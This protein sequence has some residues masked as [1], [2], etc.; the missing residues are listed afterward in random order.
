MHWLTAKWN[1]SLRVMRGNAVWP[2]VERL[3]DLAVAIVKYVRKVGICTLTASR[4][5][6]R[7]KTFR[8]CCEVLRKCYSHYQTKD[9]KEQPLTP[10]SH[11]NR[12][13]MLKDATGQVVSKT[14]KNGG[15]GG[16]RFFSEIL[17]AA[18]GKDELVVTCCSAMRIL[19]DHE[20]R[21][22]RTVRL[23]RTM[24]RLLQLASHS[25]ATSLAGKKLGTKKAVLDLMYEYCRRS[26]SNRNTCTKS[27]SIMQILLNHGNSGSASLN[28]P[29]EL[30]ALALLQLL[31]KKNVKF[32]V[33]V[34]KNGE[35]PAINLIS[36]LLKLIKAHRSEPNYIAAVL[37]CL[38]ACVTPAANA[39]FC[40]ADSGGATS[41]LPCSAPGNPI[42]SSVIAVLQTNKIHAHL[43]CLSRGLEV[44][45]CILHRRKRNARALISGDAT[46]DVSTLLGGLVNQDKLGAMPFVVQNNLWQVPVQTNPLHVKNSTGSDGPG[47]SSTKRVFENL[48]PESFCDDLTLQSLGLERISG[49][50]SDVADRPQTEQGA[51]H[52]ADGAPRSGVDSETEKP[53]Q[54]GDV[55]AN[56][57]CRGR[58]ETSPERCTGSGVAVVPT[59]DG[60]CI[61]TIDRNVCTVP[62]DFGP[63]TVAAE[64][65]PL[66]YPPCWVEQYGGGTNTGPDEATIAVVAG[67]SSNA[68]D[69]VETDTPVS[70]LSA[71]AAEYGIS[72]NG[73]VNVSGHREA[74]ASTG[75]SPEAT[76]CT[77]LKKKS[78]QV[79]RALRTHARSASSIVMLKSAR[80]A[81]LQ[82]QE[83]KEKQ[84]LLQRLIEP[85]STRAELIF[86]FGKRVSKYLG[87]PRQSNKP[88]A[89]DD[90]MPAMTQ[91]ESAEETDASHDMHST[92]SAQTVPMLEFSNNFECANLSCVMRVRDAEYDITLWRDYNTS[93]HTQWF[94]FSAGNIRKGVEY[95]FNIVNFVKKTS[96]FQSGM[97][98]LS[99]SVKESG[100]THRVVVPGTSEHEEAR[101]H[102]IQTPTV[103]DRQR[104]SET[105]DGKL[106]AQKSPDPPKPRWV[107]CGTNICYYNNCFMVPDRD[108]AS[109]IAKKGVNYLSTLTFTYRGLHDDD[110]VFFAY[111]FPYTYSQMRRELKILAE[112]H[113]P[114]MLVT[115][116]CKTLLGNSVPLLTISEGVRS[117]RK[118]PFDVPMTQSALE[119]SPSASAPAE[120]HATSNWGGMSREL[121]HDEARP[122]FRKR[123]YVV[124]SAR[125]HPG[126]TPASWMMRGFLGFLVSSAPAASILRQRFIFKVIP[127]LNPDGVIVG[128]L[129]C[130]L[131]GYDMNRCW[132]R[133]SAAMQPPVHWARRLIGHIVRA[134]P[135]RGT[136]GV[137]VV[138]PPLAPPPGLGPLAGEGLLLFTDFHAHSR[139]ENIFMYGCDYQPPGCG[140]P[141]RV[142]PLLLSQTARQFSFSHSAFNHASKAKADCARV[143]LW[144]DFGIT[145]SYTMEATFSG[146]DFGGTRPV[147]FRSREF[148]EMGEIFGHRL[149]DVGGG[150]GPTTAGGGI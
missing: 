46:A 134:S 119:K 139:S 91:K 42:F 90:E 35:G 127:M 147:H 71:A 68:N 51:P 37:G 56:S 23:D 12:E 86:A 137:E 77:G 5:E 11:T 133:P 66:G 111:S 96:L 41:G 143:A 18:P 21:I 6:P 126:E 61:C 125:V 2:S 17:R 105:T 81:E 101:E 138:A 93:S 38:A 84:A 52:S 49:K 117:L 75:R 114:I 120:T 8:L 22:D 40:L 72:E 92:P 124:V 104:V 107:R 99:F 95:K 30:S 149:L 54:D 67:G 136:S 140:A 108:T 89:S 129:R 47:V 131:L 102:A 25:T 118:R 10:R 87:R 109:S 29:L 9:P 13:R 45:H 69:D 145:M 7:L 53:G 146:G 116:L 142:L 44:L 115:E 28:L 16:T 128:N 103:S 62:P 94:Y 76:V 74:T 50:S 65:E 123:Q 1:G 112:E 19:A 110:T 57:D 32:C 34:C 4:M 27:K 100:K 130:N 98:P 59:L 78:V 85:E 141:E 60:M 3:Q 122:G 113:R 150:V 55:S 121:D 26:D 24:D 132:T 33:A 14:V 83:L 144:R 148:E 97:R 135:N 20:K 31:L 39:K 70:L 80:E 73:D 82:G 106:P 36:V 63:G 48:F 15:S 88:I 58:F 64:R 79:P 43:A